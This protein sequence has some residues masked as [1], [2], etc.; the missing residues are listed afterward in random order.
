MKHSGSWFAVRLPLTC[1]ADFSRSSRV[2]RLF[3]ENLGDAWFE[4][5]LGAEQLSLL[6][7]EIGHWEPHLD[8]HGMDFHS[9][10]EHVG[11]AI[12]A[13]LVSNAEMA[14]ETANG[15]P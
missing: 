10:V 15:E 5:P 1:S 9:D 3:R 4:N 11:G 12:A 14:R 6:V 13:F 8:G 7:H 2:L